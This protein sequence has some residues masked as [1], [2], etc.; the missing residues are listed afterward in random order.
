[1]ILLAHGFSDEDLP[2]FAQAEALHPREPRWPYHQG[3]ILYQGD[4]DAAIPKLQRAVERCGND[5]DA[6]RLKLA[7]VLLGQ[8]HVAVAE[9]QWRRLIKGDPSHAR[10]HLGLARLA[11]QKDDLEQSMAHLSFAPNASR[12]R[13]AAH[14]LLAEVYE[15]RGD[16]A[17]AEEASRRAATL[18]DDEPWPDRFDE[19]V[20][21]LRTG[22]QVFLARADR[23][24]RQGRA[25]DAIALLQHTIKDYPDASGGWLLLGRAFLAKQDLS[26]AEEALRTASRLASDSVEIPFTLG[27]VRFLRGDPR[28]AAVYF[29]Q[30]VKLKPDFALAYYNL[31]HCLMRL[32]DRNGAIVAFRTAVSCKPDYAEAHVNLGDLL[33]QA[34]EGVEALP[35]LHDAAQL[36]PR[37]PRAKKL[38][39]QLLPS[40]AIPA[41]P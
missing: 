36:D 8:G 1:M 21:Q 39:G 40:F 15:R 4:P 23:L 30:A 25:A 14:L 5:P 29:R 32:G 17:A 33:V 41:G 2:C 28:E 18:P 27:G 10:A 6:P 7:D 16:K 3:T 20:K 13:K 19:E 35:H 9:D 12:T 38:L 22:K 34:G 37:D 31:G 24:L 11:C 26:S